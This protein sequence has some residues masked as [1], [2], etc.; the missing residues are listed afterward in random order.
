VTARTTS[1]STSTQPM[2]GI[3]GQYRYGH[4]V[5]RLPAFVGQEPI[6]VF[7]SPYIRSVSAAGGT[8]VLLTREADAESVVER[9]DGLVL[10]GGEDVDPRRYGGVPTEFA[11]VLDPGRDAFE[12]ALFEAALA[13]GIPVLGICR[14]CQLINVAR[15]G[16]LI[17]HLSAS[18]GQAHSF[19]GYPG[20][21]R[22][23]TVEVAEDSKLAKLLGR[24]VQVN[25]YHHQ[26]VLT[27]GEGV[28]ATA[29]ALDGVVEGIEI[30]GTDV[31]AVQWHPEMFGGDPLFDWIVETA[32]SRT[33]G[34][35]LSEHHLHA[36]G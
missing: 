21:H 11:T 29:H 35:E 5:G 4:E 1:P 24:R 14:G 3:T 28:V 16:T 31:V 10:A 8:P 27:A 32:T 18:T 19:Y 9:L 7:L 6:E 25:S 12:V 22:P 34:S 26:A 2:I 15:G 20:S 30:P 17:S 36:A 13:K 33:R 23:Q